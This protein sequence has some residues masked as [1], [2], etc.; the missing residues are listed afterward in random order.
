MILDDLAHAKES[1]SE[2]SADPRGLLSVTAPLVFGRRHVV[3]AVI[4]FLKRYPLI[5]VDV[6]LSDEVVDLAARRVDVAIRRAFCLIATLWR[7]HWRRC[8]A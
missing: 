8:V 7:P 5:E 6:H 4:S 3:P 2:L 1:L